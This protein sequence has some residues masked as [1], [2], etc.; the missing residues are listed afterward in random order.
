M[1]KSILF[2]FLICI[3]SVCNSQ[4]MLPVYQGVLVSGV[5][6]K[7]WM[8]RNLGATQVATSSTDAASYGDLYQWGRLA[9]G[10]QLINRSTGQ[11][12]NGTTPALSPSDV[13]GN[14]NFITTN[15]SPYDWRSGQNS[16]LWQGV[17]GTNNPCP[18]GY[19]LPTSAEWQAEINNGGPGFWGTGSKQSSGAGAFTALKLPLAGFR[20]Y[21][22]GSLN[23]VGNVGLYWSSTVSG[24]N[25]GDLD[26]NSSNANMNTI[27][28]AYGLSVRC[29][30]D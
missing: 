2:L 18:A 17:S 10:H 4:I 21:S 24:A 1:K 22:D 11:A 30:K 12:V 5:A 9:D 28:R 7:I 15:T 25:A 13:P 19:R 3:G 16:N 14:F 6:G 27:S 29:L 20:Y 23:Y 8:D 26:F